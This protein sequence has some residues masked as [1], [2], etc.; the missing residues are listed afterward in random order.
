MKRK[1]FTNILQNFIAEKIN[2]FKVELWH[3]KIYLLGFA[4]DEDGN[5]YCTGK[6]HLLKEY[7]EPDEIAMLAFKKKIESW[8]TLWNR[9]EK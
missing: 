1:Q 9:L 2:T 3:D 6:R 4:E 8:L 5:T 7:Q